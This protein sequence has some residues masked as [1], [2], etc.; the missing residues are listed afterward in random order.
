MY[1][2]SFTLLKVIPFREIYMAGRELLT[3]VRSLDLSSR[4]LSIRLG[5]DWGGG[6]DIYLY[7]IR[8]DSFSSN[9]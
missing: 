6:R 9:V 4:C 3:D 2:T 7:V 8:S 1:L 5:S